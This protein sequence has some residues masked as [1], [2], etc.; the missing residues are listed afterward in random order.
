MDADRT[1]CLTDTI[2]RY[3]QNGIKYYHN[4]QLGN[5]NNVRL[6]PRLPLRFDFNDAEIVK[7]DPND[8][9]TRDVFQFYNR[10]PQARRNAM[11][12]NKLF[13]VKRS[14][15]N[16]ANTLLWHILSLMLIVASI[17]HMKRIVRT[18][19]DDHSLSTKDK[20]LFRLSFVFSFVLV[21]SLSCLM[22]LSLFELLRNRDNLP[23]ITR[24]NFRYK[25]LLIRDGNMFSLRYI[26]LSFVGICVL[27]SAAETI[28]LFDMK[29]H[30]PSILILTVPILLCLV[31]LI[32]LLSP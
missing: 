1:F 15:Y 14:V 7:M 16:Q 21:L 11:D 9:A 30:K 6:R 29:P 18:M 31:L 28:N 4:L 10:Y 13:Q 2:D 25:D 3:T 8:P 12:I 26:V 27:V 5:N 23:T 24:Y 22:A 17:A 32:H 19:Q 20:M